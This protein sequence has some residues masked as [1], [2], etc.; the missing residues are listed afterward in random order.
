MITTLHRQMAHF[1]NEAFKENLK[2]QNEDT[3][4]LELRYIDNGE[5]KQRNSKLHY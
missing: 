2:E 5:H 4:D 3:E 1:C